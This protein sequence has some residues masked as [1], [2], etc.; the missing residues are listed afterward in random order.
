MQTR[1]RP[2]KAVRRLLNRRRY[3][4]DLLATAEL[5]VHEKEKLT[6]ELTAINTTLNTKR[7]MSEYESRLELERAARIED[8]HRKS[9][10]GKWVTILPAGAP[11]LGKKGH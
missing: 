6:R 2:Q 9:G 1:N 7:A 8:L 5:T 4:T 11:G 10:F 3:V